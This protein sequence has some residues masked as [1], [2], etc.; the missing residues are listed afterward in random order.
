[1]V[2]PSY[3]T[4]KPTHSQGTYPMEV[5]RFFE[6]PESYI[7]PFPNLQGTAISL[8]N[9][10][11]AVQLH[12][13]SLTLAPSLMSQQSLYEFVIFKSWIGV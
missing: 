12:F 2:S 6:T 5:F 3:K 4:V 13:H 7:F 8:A 10:G 1:M 11:V 9:I